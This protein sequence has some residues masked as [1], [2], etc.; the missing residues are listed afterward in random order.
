MVTQQNRA[1]VRAN[2]HSRFREEGPRQT[3][4]R[5]LMPATF[6]HLPGPLGDG[7]MTWRLSLQSILLVL[8]GIALAARPAASFAQDAALR[9]AAALDQVLVNAIEK[10]GK[11][12]VAIAR[13]DPFEAARNGD[14]IQPRPRSPADP[15][16]VPDHFG[17]GVIVDRAGYIVTQY[18]VVGVKSEHYVTTTEGHVYRATIQGADPAAIWQC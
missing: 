11:S 18:H 15:D 2:W 9:S 1:R 6:A 8:A 14:R 7:R 13:V 3:I 12:I 5:S 4:E 16:F 10:A 17:T